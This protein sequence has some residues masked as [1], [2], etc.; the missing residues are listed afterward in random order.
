MAADGPAFVAAAVRAACLAKAPRRTVSAVAAAVAAVFAH[1]HASATS[2]RKVAEQP[3]AQCAADVVTDEASPPTLVEALRS[4]RRAQ[5]RRKKE[6]RLAA[7]AQAAM[8]SS[9]SD[10]RAVPEPRDM[11]ES[12][13]MHSNASQDE[14][15]QQAKP[16]DERATGSMNIGERS[17]QGSRASSMVSL[18]TRSDIG[19]VWTRSAETDG[20]RVRATGRVA[21]KPPV[22]SGRPR[23]GRTT[24]RR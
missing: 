14:D 1:Q 2:G 22:R 15:E 10:G 17:S 19:E 6:R 7:K 9:T 8:E 13:P 23:G 16:A 21:A 12:A 11:D 20:E 5:R 4:A 3:A 24:G 18:K